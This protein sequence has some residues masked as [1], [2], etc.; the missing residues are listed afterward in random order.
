[1]APECVGVG[2]VPA[3]RDEEGASLGGRSAGSLLLLVCAEESPV[4]PSLLLSLAPSVCVLQG[5][6]EPCQ[7]GGSKSRSK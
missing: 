4:H 2:P 7:V 6:R 1:M 5:L 3:G